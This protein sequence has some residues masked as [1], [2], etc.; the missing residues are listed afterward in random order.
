MKKKIPNILVM[1]RIAMIPV[2]LWLFEQPTY[3]QIGNVQYTHEFGM[4]AVLV[5]LFAAFTDFLDGFLARRWDAVSNFGK[6]MDPLADKLLVA[7]ALIALVYIRALPHWAVTIII[8]REFL[9]TGLR[10][11]ALEQGRPV[12]SA[13]I[14]GKLKTVS[15]MVMIAFLM[16]WTYLMMWV[17]EGRLSN[18]IHWEQLRDFVILFALATTIISGAEYIWKNRD[19]LKAV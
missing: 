16:M 4:V 18:S 8:S 19:V 17:R 3:T 11:L 5:F 6:L 7:A 15:H 14:W 12:I 13:S 1:V 9:V 2:F 10:M